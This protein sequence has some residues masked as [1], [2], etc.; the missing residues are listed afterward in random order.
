MKYY[1]GLII[2]SIYENNFGLQYMQQQKLE[3]LEIFFTKEMIDRVKLVID[4]I[5][6]ISIWIDYTILDDFCY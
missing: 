1:T 3:R 5:K 4:K 2:N 6:I